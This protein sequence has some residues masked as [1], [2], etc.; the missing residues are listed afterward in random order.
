VDASGDVLRDRAGAGRDEAG[1]TKEV[2]SLILGE[3]QSASQGP[4]DLG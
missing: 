4:D 3:S 1:Q 2:D